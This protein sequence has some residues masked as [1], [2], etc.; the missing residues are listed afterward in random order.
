MQRKRHQTG[1]GR[2]YLQAKL[3]GNLIAERGSAQP[4]HGK[5]AAGDHQVIGTDTFTVELQR[6]ALL[7]ARDLQHLRAQAHHHT[8]LFA[9]GHQHIDNL[10]RGVV[11][12]QLAQR[13]LMP[14]D[15]VLTDKIDKIPLGVTR[16]RR[17][18]KMTVLAQI[19]R[20]LNI[21]VSKVAAPAAGHQDLPAWLFT[22]IQ[23]QH[24]TTRLSG[25]CRTKHTRRTGANY[26]G[27]KPFHVKILFVN[28]RGL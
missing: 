28:C 7:V 5:P 22:V 1:A 2:Q 25:H 20:G 24:A 4:R 27:I 16:Q 19:G 9:L 8:A 26:H 13:L 10:L 6:V 23:Q 15:A 21:Q 11:A 17:F 18:A 14:R 12:E 3:L